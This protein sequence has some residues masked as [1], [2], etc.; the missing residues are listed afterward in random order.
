MSWRNALRTRSC[1]KERKS[2]S[3]DT[4][5]DVSQ[6]C[7]SKHIVKSKS[8]SSCL[9][10]LSLAL[11]R[12]ASVSVSDEEII[13]KEPKTRNLWK[14][15]AVSMSKKSRLFINAS[16]LLFS[17]NV[18]AF[19][20]WQALS[21]KKTELIR[22]VESQ[23]IC[24][25]LSACARSYASL[26]VLSE[27]STQWIVS[28]CVAMLFDPSREIR[29]KAC[30][31]IQRTYRSLGPDVANAF[32]SKV[33]SSVKSLLDNLEI[34]D[35]KACANR[36]RKEEDAI[37]FRRSVGE[38]AS[39]NED[40]EE[41]KRKDKISSCPQRAWIAHSLRSVLPSKPSASLLTSILLLTY[42]PRVNV[43]KRKDHTHPSYVPSNYFQEKYRPSRN[44]TWLSHLLPEIKQNDEIVIKTL[45]NMMWRENVESNIAVVQTSLNVFS[46]LV[47]VLSELNLKHF[48]SRAVQELLGGY[49][50]VEKIS[51]HERRVFTDRT[52]RIRE[53][54]EI[55]SLVNVEGR[56][57][58]GTPASKQYEHENEK[59][60]LRVQAVIDE[61][62]MAKDKIQKDEKNKKKA[63]S[64]SSAQRRHE[65]AV[66]ELRIELEQSHKDTI[67]RVSRLLFGLRRASRVLWILDER[68]LV[69]FNLKSQ[70]SY[71]CWEISFEYLCA[72]ILH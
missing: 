71:P 9:I 55:E 18:D 6:S 63:A 66:E 59:W 22:N 23:G 57:N 58:K 14:L 46:D 45:M 69:Y 31:S 54:L 32:C 72:E 24:D 39:E 62:P 53:V 3:Q 7:G 21:V 11:L 34:L 12:L 29:N 43:V 67:E 20:S 4:A 26:L 13:R 61:A 52:F 70:A 30:D 65:N 47:F 37:K 68:D 2:T 1:T 33:L 40:E 28:S 48:A 17:E 5:H 44:L 27:E 25:L 64:K 41:E 8:E 38:M 35:K 60:R 50:D 15:L 49:Q 19:E 10:C 56:P 36:K 42:H 51:K 16:P